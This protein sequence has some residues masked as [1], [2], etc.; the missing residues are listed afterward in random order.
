MK[1]HVLNGGRLRMRK[2]VY[3]PEAERSETIDLPVA[4]ML[5]RHGQGNVLFDTGCH[6]QVVDDAAA[7][8]GRWRR[9]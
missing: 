2:S 5:F 8:W 7:R 9:P 1:M 6:P 4:C 3:L